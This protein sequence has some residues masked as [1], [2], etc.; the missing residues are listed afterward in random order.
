MSLEI[1]NCK[2]LPFLCGVNNLDIEQIQVL[3]PEAISI[4]TSFSVGNAQVYM[5]EM[6]YDFI[7]PTLP[8]YG[9][10]LEIAFNFEY[11]SLTGMEGDPLS[12]VKL[13]TQTVNYI[14]D[15]MH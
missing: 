1:K 14:K 4:L 7:C 8:V 10:R 5:L 11:V 6:P 13:I 9:D 2:P 3:I 12:P 15:Y